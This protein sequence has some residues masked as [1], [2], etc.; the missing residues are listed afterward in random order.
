MTQAFEAGYLI[1]DVKISATNVEIRG[2]IDGA[3][4]VLISSLE[5]ACLPTFE[6]DNYGYAHGAE[7]LQIKSVHLLITVA[8]RRAET[9]GTAREKGAVGSWALRTMN[10]LRLVERTSKAKIRHLA[11][12][13]RIERSGSGFSSQWMAKRW[14]E[15]TFAQRGSFDHARQSRLRKQWNLP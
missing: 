11:F 12:H 6:D 10:R 1:W 3:R 14:T 9:S 8:W 2:W 5:L 13:D 4:T 15:F 7:N